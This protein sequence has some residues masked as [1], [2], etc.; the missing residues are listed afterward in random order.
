MRTLLVFSRSVV[1]EHSVPALAD[2]F[3]P[4]DMTDRPDEGSELGVRR[5][6]REIVDRNVLAFRDHDDMGRRLR[7]DVVK[8]ED[9]LV[10]IGL[11][12][13]QFAA[14]DAGAT[15]IRVVGQGTLGAVLLRSLVGAITQRGEEADRKSTRLNSSH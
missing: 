13:G 15:V 3:L 10:L 5:F 8:G 1:L 12:A 14:K 4:R 11:A 7:I 6:L 2:P 9:V